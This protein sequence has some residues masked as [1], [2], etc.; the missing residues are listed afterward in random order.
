MA[1]KIDLGDCKLLRSNANY[2]HQNLQRRA[3]NVG[4]VPYC[5][6]AWT[7]GER[8]WL[9]PVRFNRNRGDGFSIT[10]REAC[11]I[12][13]FDSF[14]M[15]LSCSTFAN[16]SNAYYICVV[17]KE[18]VVVLLRKIDDDI[19]SLLKEYSAECI[20]QGCVWHP[21]LPQVAVLSKSSAVL[22]C[23]TEEFSCIVIPIKTF[24]RNLQAC[25]W[26]NDGEHLAVAVDDILC[27]ISWTDWNKPSQFTYDQWNHLEA[28]GRIKCI[29]PWKTCSFM[30]ATELPLEKLLGNDEKCDLFEVENEQN[31]SDDSASGVSSFN[32][33][34]GCAII[35]KKKDQNQDVSSLL[36]FKPNMQH[37]EAP[38]TSA[39]IIA[40]GCQESKPVEIFRTNIKGLISPDLMIFQ[41][42]SN[43][44][45]VGSHCSSKLHCF[46]L[47]SHDTNW[48]AK[49]ECQAEDKILELDANVKPK[50]MC[51]IPGNTDSFLVLLGK[52]KE[53]SSMAPFPP[54]KLTDFY[55]ASLQC[56]SM[57]FTENNVNEL[58]DKFSQP[59]RKEHCHKHVDDLNGYDDERVVLPSS[60]S[61]PSLRLPNGSLARGL[62]P[63][64]IE[65]R[66]PKLISELNAS[67]C[68]KI[69]G[70]STERSQENFSCCLRYIE[71]AKA[72]TLASLST[73]TDELSILEQRLNTIGPNQT[74]YPLPDSAEF[75]TVVWTDELTGA[76]EQNNFLLDKGRLRLKT[77]KKAFR[78]SLVRMS[79][80]DVPCIVS[81]GENGF[82]PVRFLSGTTVQMSGHSRLNQSSE[83][84]A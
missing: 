13:E 63:S 42:A 7:D 22:L 23:F 8:V 48:K 17:M 77:V 11:L 1:A 76:V 43:S 2:L 39:H 73:L 6:L 84:K 82:I 52:S 60:D 28:C 65:N 67:D 71:E 31:C 49:A 64:I 80:G 26:S 9:S 81:S 18:K 41:P 29:A 37:F 21:S 68:P 47:P 66:M 38:S 33:H 27:I 3:E 51:L 50:G 45:I 16:G 32:P 59:N 62:S 53:V 58:V 54:S 40:I 10:A 70:S 69:N 24:H 56:F 34:D 4:N 25:A 35:T 78:A 75:V 5:E 19:F 61:P 57:S 46:T 15:G 36:K 55:D 74:L 30:V 14:V 12:G 72:A 83:R 79:I 44:V 20:S